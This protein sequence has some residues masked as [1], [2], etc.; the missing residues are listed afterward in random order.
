V[1]AWGDEECDSEPLSQ[2]VTSRF[3]DGWKGARVNEDSKAVK[4]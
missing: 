1:G 2:E 4:Q 3:A